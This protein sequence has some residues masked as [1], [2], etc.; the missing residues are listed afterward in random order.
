MLILFDHCTPMPLRRHL[1]GHTVH[2]A[3]DMGWH[4]ISNGRL[5]AQAEAAGYEL[6]ISGDQGIYYQQNLGNANLAIITLSE[7]RWPQVRLKVNEIREAVD[8]ILPGEFV[9]V[10]IP[11]PERRRYG[12]S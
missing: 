3:Y 1:P 9:E 2:A 11:A 10:E 8:R 6:L 12:Q 4:T 5:I 7:N